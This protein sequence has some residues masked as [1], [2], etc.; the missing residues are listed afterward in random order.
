[1]EQIEFEEISKGPSVTRYA[2]KLNG[3]TVGVAMRTESVFISLDDPG[4][5]SRP[6]VLWEAVDSTGKRRRGT[7]KTRKAAGRAVVYYWNEREEERV[8]FAAYNSHLTQS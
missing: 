2:V 8:S 3:R 4:K 6:V 7:Y 1:M 5:A